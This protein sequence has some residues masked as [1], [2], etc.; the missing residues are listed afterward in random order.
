MHISQEPQMKLSLLK[1]VTIWYFNTTVE[2]KKTLRAT[3]HYGYLP[4]DS[5]K[6]H[7]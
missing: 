6:Y 7:N 1:T 3:F 5:I 4:N 2:N